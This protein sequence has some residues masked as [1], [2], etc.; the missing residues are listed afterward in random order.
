MHAIPSRLLSKIF[1]LGGGRTVTSQIFAAPRP[2]ALSR[3]RVGRA[4]DDFVVSRAVRYARLAYGFS[5]TLVS[6]L[7]RNLLTLLASPRGFEPMLPP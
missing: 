2:D 6:A 3:P 5:G 7:S 1:R 4:R